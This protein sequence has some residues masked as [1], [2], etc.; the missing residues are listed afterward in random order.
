MFPFDECRRYDRKF[1][2]SLYPLRAVRENLIPMGRH[3]DEKSD[4]A[5][6][7]NYGQI[8]TL[9]YNDKYWHC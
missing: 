7:L 2:I 5:T 3:E 8:K 9:R 4:R 6:P 1:K